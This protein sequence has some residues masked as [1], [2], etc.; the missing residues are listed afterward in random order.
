MENEK[1]EEQIINPGR[2]GLRGQN[3]P[4]RPVWGV[5]TLPEKSLSV[6]VGLFMFLCLLQL[7]SCHSCC[8]LP[9]CV[10]G[11]L[12][13]HHVHHTCLTLHAITGGGCV[14]KVWGRGTRGPLFFCFLANYVP[15]AEGFPDWTREALVWVGVGATVP[16]ALWWILLRILTM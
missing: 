10:S 15:D 2:Q 16:V 9:V 4:S 1:W 14:K 8:S 13:Q 11:P 7:L 6:S 3:L 12:P 5:W